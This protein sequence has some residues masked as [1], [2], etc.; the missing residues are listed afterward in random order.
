M[1]KTKKNEY[2]FE[3]YI[4]LDIFFIESN[5]LLKQIV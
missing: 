4:N 5:I 2:D 3:D 1:I